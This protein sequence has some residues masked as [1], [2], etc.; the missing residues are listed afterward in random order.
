MSRIH[1]IFLAELEPDK[2]QTFERTLTHLPVP[3]DRIALE[4]PDDP[5]SP[6]GR[7]LDLVVSRQPYQWDFTALSPCD[8]REA[9]NTVTIVLTPRVMALSEIVAS[10]REFRLKQLAATDHASS[11]EPKLEHDA[12]TKLVSLT[13]ESL[14]PPLRAVPL[15]YT[16]E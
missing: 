12:V 13:A 5:D 3:G 16:Q 4:D 10:H 8:W 9:L 7:K 2:S 1:V 6:H 11:S 15:Y 14:L